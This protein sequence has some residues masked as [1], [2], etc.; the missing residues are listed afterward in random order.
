MLFSDPYLWHIV[1]K[2]E[3]NDS[4]NVDYECHREIGFVCDKLPN[5]TTKTCV[6]Q[7]I[8]FS[9]NLLP[10]F[11]IC[12]ADIYWAKDSYCGR[13]SL[14]H[15]LLYVSILISRA[16][17]DTTHCRLHRPNLCNK[18]FSSWNEWYLPY[19]YYSIIDSKRTCI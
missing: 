11:Q 4:C 16:Y 8:D 7:F 1:R 2:G 17:N 6:C 19:A 15:S 10:I 3:T 18:L 5:V 14:L 9:I 13:N 12:A